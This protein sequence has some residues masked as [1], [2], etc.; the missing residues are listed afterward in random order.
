MKGPLGAVI[1]GQ[2]CICICVIS[3]WHHDLIADSFAA[4]VVVVVVNV[5]VIV[6][7]V[8]GGCGGFPTL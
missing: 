4:V 5:V 3:C 7:V 8:V 1:K 2:G 6:V